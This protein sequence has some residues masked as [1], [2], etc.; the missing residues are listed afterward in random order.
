M[1]FLSRIRIF[2]LIFILTLWHALAPGGDDLC[3]CLL[4]EILQ[5]LGTGGSAARIGSLARAIRGGTQGAHHSIQ[6]IASFRQGTNFERD[7]HSWASRQHFSGFLPDPYEFEL[8]KETKDGPQLLSHHAILPH[9]LFSCLYH[10]AF[11]LFELLFTGPP[12]NLLQFWIDAERDGGSWFR[13][14]PVIQLQ[15]DPEKRVPFGLHGDDAGAQGEETVL[16][17][18]WGSVA[19]TQSPTFDSRLIFCIFKLSEMVRGDGYDPTIQT[20]YEVFKWSLNALSSG[21][22][23]YKDYLGQPF[24]EMHHRDRFVLAGLDLA[25]G[26]CGA[27]SEVRGDWK[28][29]K[30]SFYL[31]NYYGAHY[32][33]HLCNA[34]VSIQRL[35]YT[36]YRRD[37]QHRN[38][39]VD[40]VLWW[41]RYAAAVL[42]SPLIYIVGFNIWRVTFDIMHCLELGVDQYAAPSTVWELTESLE[43]GG[44][45]EGNSRHERFRDLY[46]DYSEWVKRNNLEDKARRFNW[47]QWRKNVNE[48]GENRL[49]SKYPKISQQVM[50]AATLR[51]F[52]YYLAE[53]CCRPSA[54][55]TEHGQI[56]AAMYR[57]FVAADLVMRLAGKFITGDQRASL[58][59][60]FESAFTAYNA[61]SERCRIRR[62]KLYKQIPK[63][64]ALMHLAFDFPTNPRRTACMQDEDMVGRAKRLYNG[65]HGKSA[66]K[67]SLQRYLIF[68]GLRWTKELRRLR[69]AALA[70]NRGG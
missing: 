64:H 54:M 40:A 16:V 36:N 56:R 24:S 31:E 46:K 70:R 65:C 35:R 27:F 48:I 4:E 12:G 15:P 55:R 28:W 5:P 21:K 42:V 50:K 18:N 45:F 11:E 29:I 19:I 63:G 61:L 17:L 37:A 22:F 8:L 14:H 6:E 30:E 59:D 25:E 69:L 43:D 41:T 68:I 52:M 57:E 53:I 23:P 7:L 1:Q 38:T 44:I 10:K 34:H 49:N 33:C 13:L 58:V 26:F 51:S 66:P 47:K 9:E 39:L 3:P 20:I 67:R 32:I 60:H 62:Q 2:I